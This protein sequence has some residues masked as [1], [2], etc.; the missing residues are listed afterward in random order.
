MKKIYLLVMLVSAGALIYSE[1][2]EM[3]RSE[4]RTRL[5]AVSSQ[6]DADIREIGHQSLHAVT[7][8]LAGRFT[9]KSG[10]SEL[11][12]TL[13]DRINASLSQLESE[14]NW[15]IH[16][17]FISTILKVDGQQNSPVPRSVTAGV[18][19][20][21]QALG[22]MGPDLDNLFTH[23]DAID[24]S[25]VRSSVNNVIAISDAVTDLTRNLQDQLQPGSAMT[26]RVLSFISGGIVLLSLGGLFWSV[27]GDSRNT[28]LAVT[29]LVDETG[30]LAEGDLTVKAQVTGD[31]T[32][33]VADSINR[34]I[35]EMHGLV[36]GIRQA[37]GE[38]SQ[39]TEKAETLI[40]RL[41]THRI[42]QS[43]EISDSADDVTN[44][45]DGIHRISELATS[46]TPHIRECVKFAQRGANT[47]R[48]TVQVM[49][50][51]R[52]EIQETRNHL[53]RLVERC[54]EINEIVSSIRDATEQI[55]MLSLNASIQA[56]PGESGRSFA[57][58][59]E[60]VRSLTER[61]A[62]ASNGI[63]ELVE[64]L[65]Q[66]ADNAMTCVRAAIREVAS[67]TSGA[68]QVRRTLNEIETISQH[69]PGII[70]QLV[71]D[72]QNQSKFVENVGKRMEILQNS[73]TGS[74][75]DEAQVA[76]A[77]EKMKTVANRLERSTKGFRLS[78]SPSDHV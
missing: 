46:S 7:T 49:E 71:D 53:Q 25:S 61:S 12:D 66:D 28:R 8:K 16:P 17:Q 74:Y 31:I 76:I 73:T 15:R 56:A 40:A 60:E 6:L 39:T 35:S 22:K 43:G 10:S 44:L 1:C 77:L 72:I 29:R 33:P 65:Q 41:K 20:I 4:N 9:G 24:P 19:R 62:H 27:L 30:G 57:G 52:N 48:D 38:V 3:A 45:S 59:A 51:A 26:G 37:A 63:A 32:A 64:D 54:R 5:N 70:D 34:A 78:D 50:A 47:T 75:L 18:A 36:T 14:D 42:F 11:A 2:L 68:D 58:T 21:E 55:H 69:L 23:T 67:G 13:I